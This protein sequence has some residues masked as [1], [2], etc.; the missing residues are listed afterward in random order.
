MS[1][2]EGI[3]DVL[4]HYG[5]DLTYL[6]EMVNTVCDIY[7]QLDPRA[8]KKLLR[9]RASTP[10]AESHTKSSKIRKSKRK[11][12]KEDLTEAKLMGDENSMIDY[13]LQIYPK[14]T[15]EEVERELTRKSSKKASSKGKRKTITDKD[16]NE[17]IEFYYFQFNEQL[18][19]KIIKFMSNKYPA[20]TQREISD[21]L[22]KYDF[23]DKVATPTK[24]A[25]S[26]GSWL[27]KTP[28][29]RGETY[30]PT[31]FSPSSYGAAS[32]D[33]M[34]FYR[35]KRSK[36]LPGY[37]SPPRMPMPSPR[38]STPRRRFRED[39]TPPPPSPRRGTRAASG[40]KLS[41]G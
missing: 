11:I 22:R 38:L 29:R 32:T 40:R 27:T 35:S 20:M 5:N 7:P 21:E 28:L 36:Y 31:D 1:M 12:A 33:A 19:E 25:G 10:M 24:V 15:Y 2:A 13:L 39:L 8:V 17:A 30:V 26:P 18:R 41:F 6:P 4:D 23:G 3:D 34:D 9:K 16:V 37:V 14:L